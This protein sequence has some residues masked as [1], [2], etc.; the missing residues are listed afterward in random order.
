MTKKR[1]EGST[2]ESLSKL[3][4]ED[5]KAVEGKQDKAQKIIA[6]RHAVTASS[7]KGLQARKVWRMIDKV[8][9][10]FIEAFALAMDGKGIYQ[11]L[12]KKYGFN[13]VD[14]IH[15]GYSLAAITVAGY[16]N[17]TK[18][19]GLR[20]LTTSGNA[21]LLALLTNGAIAP[22][23]PSGY[24]RK[25]GYFDKHGQLTK[26]GFIWLANRF[27]DTSENNGKPY[28]PTTVGIVMPILRAMKDKKASKVKL[29]SRVNPEKT[30]TLDFSSAVSQLVK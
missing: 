29:A 6:K 2:P 19:L 16:V 5:K 27:T 3:V 30:V 26:D 20:K 4:A 21:G 12:E 15:G 1:K 17:I 14:G 9:T 22:M 11:T 25:K 24:H 28:Y 10:L 7:N 18:A 8:K 23:K 13:P